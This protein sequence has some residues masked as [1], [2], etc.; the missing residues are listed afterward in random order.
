MTR[1]R[2]PHHKKGSVESMS[3][4]VDQIIE[5]PDAAPHEDYGGTE[6]NPLSEP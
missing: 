4:L 6:R 3:A 5:A 1:G 2:R